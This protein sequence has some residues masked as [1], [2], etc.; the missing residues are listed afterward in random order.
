MIV[1][2]EDAWDGDVSVAAVNYPTASF[3]P[4]ALTLRMA[5]L[6]GCGVDDAP[7]GEPLA[8]FEAAA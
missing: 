8:S 2:I 3:D 5:G 7:L 6:G 1:N 4:R